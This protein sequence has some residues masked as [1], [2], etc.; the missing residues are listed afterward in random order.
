VEMWTRAFYARVQ[1]RGAAGI[2]TGSS[3][4]DSI[5]LIGRAATTMNHADIR[6]LGTA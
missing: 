6:G 2:S 3:F 4:L 5:Q 1:G